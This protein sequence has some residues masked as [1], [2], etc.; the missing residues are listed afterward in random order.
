MCF[1]LWFK[2]YTVVL[3]G[4]TKPQSA[5]NPLLLCVSVLADCVCMHVCVCVRALGASHT[6]TLPPASWD[7]K[8]HVLPTP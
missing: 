6:V 4:K 8:K 2:L 1:A 3:A 5:T 7:R